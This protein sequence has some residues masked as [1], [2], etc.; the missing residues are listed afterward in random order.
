MR[1]EI[2]FMAGVAG[3]FGLATTAFTREKAYEVFKRDEGECQCC[4]RSWYDGWKVDASHKEEWHDKSHPEYNNPDNGELK[5]LECH[6][7]E[8]AGMGELREADLVQRRIDASR[9]GLRDEYDLVDGIP[10]I[11]EH[12]ATQS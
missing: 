12:G 4:G 2:A 6:R 11:R 3:I 8:H 1:K 10:V 7:D 9:G 5:C